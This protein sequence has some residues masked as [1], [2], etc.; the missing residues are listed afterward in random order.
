MFLSKKR[1]LAVLFAT[2]VLGIGAN[3][4]ASLDQ[5]PGSNQI[6]LLATEPLARVPERLSFPEAVKATIDMPVREDRASAEYVLPQQALVPLPSGAWMGLVSLG[7]L[8]LFGSR[9]A[10]VKFVT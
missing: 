4:N 7:V 3:A 8:T 6:A 1:S 5:K 9:K 2:A 10:I